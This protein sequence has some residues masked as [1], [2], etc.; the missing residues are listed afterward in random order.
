MSAEPKMVREAAEAELNSWCES[1]GV[2]V[3]NEDR[4][5]LL[6]A[7]MFGRIIFDPKTEE[8][9]YSLRTSVKLEN[10]EMLT[11]VK[12]ADI[13]AKEFADAYKTIK[14]SAGDRTASVSMDSV[15]MQLSAA[16]GLPLGVVQRIKNRDFTVLQ[17]LSSFFG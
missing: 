16:S 7:L 9:L 6:S 8:F 10:G 12:I 4:E 13:T 17:V 2:K 5:K 3:N 1:L 15:L 14:M 11:S